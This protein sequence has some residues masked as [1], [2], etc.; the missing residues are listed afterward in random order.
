MRRRPA[1]TA[2]VIAVAT[3]IV[4]AGPPVPLRADE[5]PPQRR[6][7]FDMVAPETR[8]MQADD[9]SNPGILWVA[10]G[11]RLWDEPPGAAGLACAGCHGAAGASMRGVATRYPA[12]DAASRRPVDLAGRI[13]L[14][15]TGEQGAAAL[16]REGD[17]LLALTAF[18]AHQSRGLPIAPP[19]DPELEPFRA[20]GEALYK[21]RLGQLALSCAD[22]HDRLAGARLGGN[23]VP[24]AHPTGYPIY[25]LEWQTL[26]SLRRRLRNCMIGVR[27]EP[28]EPGSQALVELELFL[29]NRAAGMPLETPGVR[30]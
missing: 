13:N 28:F 23:V 30:P 16:P 29:M 12:L 22:C 3:A 25:R 17:D 11:A 8:A 20:A 24:E 6:S 27:A 1:Q 18:V 10:D 9:T 15:R 19:A 4:A 26:G 7:G 5:A 2:V 21:R 14:C